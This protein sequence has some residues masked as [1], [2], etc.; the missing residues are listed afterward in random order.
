MP[1]IFDYPRDAV[2]TYGN[3]GLHLRATREPVYPFINPPVYSDH[4]RFLFFEAE[5]LIEDDPLQEEERWGEPAVE[6]RT[7]R[8]VRCIRNILNDHLKD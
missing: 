7:R 8:S 2:S 1:V 5:P 4:W 6:R 3:S